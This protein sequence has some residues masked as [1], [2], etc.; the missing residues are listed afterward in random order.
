MSGN[1]QAHVRKHGGLMTDENYLEQDISGEGEDE[2]G[3][4]E[5]KAQGGG[6]AISLDMWGED[7]RAQVFENIGQRLEIEQRW[8]DDIA[9]Y[10]GYRQNSGSKDLPNRGFNR[11]RSKVNAGTGR[12]GDLLFPGDDKNWTLRPS[13]VPD[14]VQKLGDNTPVQYEGQQ[15][16][17]PDGQPITQGM[18]A[19][20]KVEIATEKCHKMELHIHDQLNNS[21]YGSEA[22]AA[23]FDSALLG[24]GILKGPVVEGFMRKAW[25]QKAGGAQELVMAHQK[26]PVARRI[27]PWNFVPDMQA[28][29]VSECDI[30]FERFYQTKFGLKNMVTK[31]GFNSRAFDT[32]LMLGAGASHI[33][34]TQSMQQLRQLTGI[35]PITGDNRW[36][37]W[38]AHCVVDTEQLIQIGAALPEENADR[39]MDQYPAIC[40]FIGNQIIKAVVSPLDTGEMPFSVF[41]WEPDESC[42][43]GFGVPHLSRNSQ[44]TLNQAADDML[45]NANK[46]AGGQVVVRKKA[47]EPANGKW[48][49]EPNKLWYA[50]DKIGEA[51]HA[52]E[53]YR[54]DNHQQAYQN[55][56]TI[57]SQFMDEETLI[58]NI[59]NGEQG[60]PNPTTGGTAMMLN[61]A[62]TTTRQKIRR[63]DDDVTTGMLTRF[64]DWNM[65]NN[66]DDSIKGDFEVIPTGTT[67]MLMREILAMQLMQIMSQF[68][69]HPIL[70]GWTKVETLYKEF[71]KTTNIPPDLAVRSQEEYDQ[72]MQQ[73]KQAQQGQG[74]SPE[75]MEHEWRMA[76]VQN[77]REANQIKL[78]ELASQERIA[79]MELRLKDK[80]SSQE[81]ERKMY[82]LETR[83]KVK[84]HEFN[85][86][87]KV[88]MMKHAD[89]MSGAQQVAEGGGEPFNPPGRQG[90]GGVNVP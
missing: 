67:T 6:S 39:L 80:I 77:E 49:I 28:T 17:G 61:A 50:T 57:A 86:S 70:G 1:T 16:L 45:E 42:I 81:F 41:T 60:V 12:I 24:T 23:L 30:I 48:E 40:W 68:S 51:K 9:Q 56:I 54:F 46:T 58:P 83:M 31:H 22:R 7:L 3:D 87:I 4:R 33:M 10:Y 14:L 35:Q 11:T 15:V 74:P 34:P 32:A 29:R 5:I 90:P 78:Q 13:P 8:V 52:F 18:V 55:V 85:T 63:W 79:L 38:K 26:R 19:K 89:D 65:L 64:Y 69:N 27:S 36:E 66:P 59:M 2:Q 71:I 20:R 43:F 76:R 25:V 73:Q 53:V 37:I 88:E 72:W 84:L 47:I 62:L 75:Q 21:R 44:A 82:D